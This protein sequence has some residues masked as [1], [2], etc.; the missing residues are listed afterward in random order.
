MCPVT[1]T[2]SQSSTVTVTE[3]TSLHQLQPSSC[4]NATLQLP[5]DKNEHIDLSEFEVWVRALL[6]S[7]K[8]AKDKKARGTRRRSSTGAAGPEGASS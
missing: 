2:A 4:C 3:T 1:V 5:Q 7:D 6:R 8:E